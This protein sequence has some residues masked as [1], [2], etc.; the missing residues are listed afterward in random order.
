MAICSK[1]G[2]E[3]KDEHVQQDV[4]GNPLCGLCA[5]TWRHK[6]ATGIAGAPEVAAA[7]GPGIWRPMAYG[8]LA[9]TV[10][11][12]IITLSAV[13]AR[14]G[15]RKD[16]SNLKTKVTGLETD[17]NLK[18]QEVA[19]LSFSRANLDS[20]VRQLEGQL[21]TRD[22][23]IRELLAEKQTPPTGTT[24]PG[25]GTGTGKTPP[26]T[27][28]GKTPPTT[29]TGEPPTAGDEKIYVNPKATMYHKTGCKYVTKASKVSTLEEVKRRKLPPCKTCNPPKY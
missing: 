4:E 24:P 19:D 14:S 29:G 22:A 9:A 11:M 26:T 7:T 13:S 3:V 2:R 16:I 27:G 28:T 21:A 23:R 25:T 6:S 5:G 1:C 17:L 20:Q 12:L 8:G 15:L 18:K 10:V